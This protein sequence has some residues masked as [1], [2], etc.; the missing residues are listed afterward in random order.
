MQ[1]LK[2][3]LKSDLIGKSGATHNFDIV[4][5]KGADSVVANFTFE[6]KE[7]DIIGLF[8]K[9]YDV[10]SHIHTPHSSY[11]SL[12]RGGDCKQS[13]RSHDHFFHRNQ[14]HRGANNQIS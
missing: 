1:V 6:P 3:G 7:E 14:I 12:K 9:K 4:A 5:R 10:D 2:S 11:T 13:I 8:A